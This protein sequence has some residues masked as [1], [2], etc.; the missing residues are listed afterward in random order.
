MGYLRTRKIYFFTC[1]SVLNF[2]FDFRYWKRIRNC[3]KIYLEISRY[4]HVL[5][6]LVT[7]ILHTDLLKLESLS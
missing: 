5:I 2:T 1:V 6:I 3:S 4:R 7:V